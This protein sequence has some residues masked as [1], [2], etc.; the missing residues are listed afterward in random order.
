MHS[1]CVSGGWERTGWRAA[2]RSCCGAP[3]HI[4]DARGRPPV[5]KRILISGGAGFVG[6][7]LVDALMTQVRVARREGGA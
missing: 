4:A 1:K 6:S 5:Q 2:P 3:V 7:N